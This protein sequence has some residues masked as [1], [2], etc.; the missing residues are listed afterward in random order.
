ME[1]G[2]FLGWNHMQVDVIRE[3]AKKETEK[4]KTFL[5]LVKTLDKVGWDEFLD[6]LWTTVCNCSIGWA[7]YRL[8]QQNPELKEVVGEP[9]LD[10]LDM[11]TPSLPLQ[12]QKR[13]CILLAREYSSHL[14]FKQCLEITLNVAPI[15]YKLYNQCTFS[16][17]HQVLELYQLLE[18]GLL[19]LS[20]LDTFW[21]KVKEAAED[22]GILIGVLDWFNY[23]GFQHLVIP[24]EEGLDGEGSEHSDLL[25]PSNPL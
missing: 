12:E 1:I 5:L 25:D 19:K 2:L 15:H 6:L 8:V 4:V 23:H 21:E 18:K 10:F 20:K 17:H 7:F 24:S 22:A 16:E 13:V 11:H 14:V 9:D 3:E